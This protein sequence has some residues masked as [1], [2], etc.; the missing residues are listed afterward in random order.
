MGTLLGVCI[1]REENGHGDMWK[2]VAYGRLVIS[3]WFEAER[4][5]GWVII[6]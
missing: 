2:R 3:A 1:E 6:A 4:E 5:N